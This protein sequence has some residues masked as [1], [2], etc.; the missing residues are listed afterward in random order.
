VRA[1]DEPVAAPPTS[2]LISALA[3]FDTPTISNAIER[4]DVR[5]R[6]IGYSSLKLRCLFPE[7]PPMV[8]H[9]ITCTAETYPA[10]GGLPGLDELLAAIEQAPKPVVLVMGWSGNDRDRGCVL[11][12]M[13]AFALSLL[14]VVGI[15]TDSAIRDPGPIHLRVPELQV[16][17]RGFVAS[18]GRSRL[19]GIGERASVGGLDI[20]RGELLHGDMNGLLAIPAGIAE[21]VPAAASAVQ[22]DELAYFRGLEREGSNLAAI[23]SRLTGYR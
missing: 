19:T 13:T 7:L 9:A 6:T 15:A 4:F 3:Q 23:R 17:A 22:E 18:H 2:E 14:G 11:G 5:D 20:E 21:E 8:G 12:E 1:A 10:T 16:F